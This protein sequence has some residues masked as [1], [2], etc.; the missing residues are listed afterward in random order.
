MTFKELGLDE[1]IVKAVEELGFEKPSPIQE[2]SIPLLIT[3]DKDYVGLAQTGT[4]KTAAFGLPMIQQIDTNSKAI[5]G[6]ILCP[7]RE[8]CLQIT[9]EL[10]LYAKHTKGIKVVAVYGGASIS[11]QI[12]EIK[13]GVN[14]MVGTP[15]RT[16]D[17]MERRVLKFDEVKTVV[18]DEA[19]EM[20]NMGFKEDIT[21]IIEQTPPSKHTWLFSATMPK[22]VE[23]IA[24]NY[25]TD[26]VRVT[27]G[28]KNSSAANIEHQYCAVAGRDQYDALRRFIDVA[29]GMYGIVFCRTRRETK[30][31]ADKLMADGYNADALHGDLSQAQRDSVMAKFRN[32]NL[33]VL[34][35]TD[36]AARGIDVD[37]LTHVFHV[38]L[39]DEIESYTHRSGRTARA[40]KSGRSIALVSPSKASR[41]RL[42][43]KQIGGKMELIQ[44]PTGKE[45][46]FQQ[47]M[48]VIQNVKKVEI[49]E[50]GLAP[51]IAQIHEEFADVSK[52]E[53]I[54]RFVSL[55]FNRFIKDYEKARDL[56]IDMSTMRKGRDRGE[57]GDRK[58]GDNTTRNTNRLFI[59][60]GKMDGFENKG[61]IL[62]FICNQTGVDGNSIG[63]I[64]L[65]DSFAFIGVDDNVGNTLINSLNGRNIENRDIRIEFSKDKP[66]G[67]RGERRDRGGDRGGYKGG[68]DR[69]GNRR[70]RT[71]SRSSFKRERRS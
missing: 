63:K 40:G 30:E 35:A 68:G 54:E 62:G 39:P 60:I 11:D 7:T 8:L 45:I 58:R 37:D 24:K 26:P 5:Q 64:D 33:Q 16:I 56:N 19:D 69:G 15:G 2:E 14:I 13:S 48:S 71:S 49:N 1:Y 27:V 18:L 44:V 57:R 3:G 29:P 53:I 47:L 22:E 34:I 4:G 41:V 43:E 65:F 55:E 9:N 70:E 31:F 32:R 61:Q 51:Y 66:K 46:C 12:R 36:V 21:K 10:K 38:D 6:M 23:R 52:E 42:V 20:L 17:L 28:T 50:K 67:E 59:N 25:M